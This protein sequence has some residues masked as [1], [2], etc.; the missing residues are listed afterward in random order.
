MRPAESLPAGLGIADIELDAA[1][2]IVA[3]HRALGAALLLSDSM[4]VAKDARHP[5][6]LGMVAGRADVIHHAVQ[7][8]R[9]AKLHAGRGPKAVVGDDL[10]F[11]FLGRVRDPRQDIAG[12]VADHGVAAVS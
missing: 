12:G 9:V 4:C 1:T 10:G 5:Q 7:K 6:C 8:E 3:D 2:H 11:H